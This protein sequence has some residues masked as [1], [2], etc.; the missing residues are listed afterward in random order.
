[1][2]IDSEQPPNPKQRDLWQP[3]NTTS[4]LS[5]W[6]LPG[7]Y[8]PKLKG[9]HFNVLRPH[10]EQAMSKQTGPP[11]LRTPVVRRAE[12]DMNQIIPQGQRCDAEC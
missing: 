1:M 7:G 3:P 12:T 4:A 9:G 10:E 5:A 11:P 8:V 2:L 6:R